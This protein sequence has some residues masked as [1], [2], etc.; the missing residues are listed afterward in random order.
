MNNLNKICRLCKKNRPLLYFV[1]NKA[2]TSGTGNECRYCRRIYNLKYMRKFRVENREYIRRIDRESRQK[3]KLACLVVYGGENPKCEC[4]EEK[5]NKF[6]SID[7]IGG[8]GTKHR[9]K[10]KM[11]GS[12]FYQWLKN[13]NF[14][15]GFRVLCHNCNFAL[16]HY[17]YCP[18]KNI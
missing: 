17:E 11:Y 12:R 7:H 1:K 15:K 8:G 16:G 14:P 5:E 2:M 10:I 18:H 6:L 13:N 4:C 9:E 3:L